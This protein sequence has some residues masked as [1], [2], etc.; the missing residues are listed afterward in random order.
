ML[1]HSLSQLFTKKIL[2]LFRLNKK[3]NPKINNK[4]INRKDPIIEIVKK[5]IEELEK[6]KF[7]YPRQSFLVLMLWER[8]SL[9]VT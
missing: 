9:K 5:Y 7:I 6:I 8:E 2:E 3:A 4:M 1:M